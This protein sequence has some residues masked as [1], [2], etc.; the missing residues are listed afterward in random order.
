MNIQ[1]NYFKIH[2]SMNNNI[3]C[4]CMMK[5]HG[6][7]STS[8]KSIDIQFKDNH[9]LQPSSFPN[10]SVCGHLR[11]IRKIDFSPKNSNI[12]YRKINVN[13]VNLKIKAPRIRKDFIF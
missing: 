13:P 11:E 9:L 8:F 5:T 2:Q 4:P 6:F 3:I 12:N 7:S 1:N 10:G